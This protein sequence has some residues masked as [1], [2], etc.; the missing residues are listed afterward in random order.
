MEQPWLKEPVDETGGTGEEAG[1]LAATLNNV[2]GKEENHCALTGWIQSGKV[3]WL[4]VSWGRVSG[5]N[6]KEV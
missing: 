5:A 1:H 6:E 3:F 4:K 2:P